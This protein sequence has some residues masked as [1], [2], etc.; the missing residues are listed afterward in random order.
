VSV[1]VAQEHFYRSSLPK[2]D[3]YPTRDRAIHSVVHGHRV[4]HLGCTDW[5]MTSQKLQQGELLHR[6]LLDWC[7]AVLGVDVDRDG[8]DVLGAELGGAYERLDVE[9]DDLTPIVGFQA[10]IVAAC[11]V[12]EHVPNIDRF[13][14]GLARLLAQSRPGCRLLITTPNALALRHLGYSAA[15]VEVIHPDHRVVFTPSTLAR[16]ARSQGLHVIGWA[17]YSISSGDTRPRQALD[18]VARLAARVR[19]P[20]ADGLA[21]TF[22][23]G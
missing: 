2:G 23:T 19:P 3:W 6:K 17:Y 14:C 21:V 7:P 16:S 5:P 12:I 8:L 11:D 1:P 20:L 18:C 4:V 22:G 10:D 9:T 13:L 15:G